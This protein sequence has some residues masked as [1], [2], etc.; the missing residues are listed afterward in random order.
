MLDGVGGAVVNGLLALGHIVVILLER[1]LALLGGVE[2]QKILEEV[3]VSAVFVAHA[4]LDVDAEVLPELLVL[5]TVVLHHL[6]KLALY[7]LFKVLTDDLELAVVLKYLTGDIQAQVGGIDNAAH[8]VE[9]IVH[10]LVAVFLNKH[11]VAVELDA[12][13]GGAAHLMVDILARDKEH[14]LVGH[15]ALGIH[16]Q[17]DCGVVLVTACLLIPLGAFLVGDIGLAALPDGHHGVNGLGLCDIDLLHD[18]VA[19]LVGLAGGLLL[20]TGNVHDYRPADIVGVFLN[21]RLELPNLQERAVDLLVGVL[22]YMHDDIRADG[23]LVAVGDGVAVSTGALPLNAGLLAVLA[24]YNGDLVG[25][26]ERRVEAHAELTDD[27]KILA[28]GLVCVH[29]ALELIR[30]G[31]CDNAE[32]GFRFGLGHADAVVGHGDEALVLIDGDADTVIGPVKADLIVGQRQV[33]QLVDSVGCIGDD[34]TQEYL[35]VGVN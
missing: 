29:L 15:I 27:G 30:A 20:L 32:V 23:V 13:L 4:A 21:Q 11:A 35:L 6:L 16:A 31:L 17:N 7:L 3:G 25:D 8:K 26:H 12:L 33:A 18:G 5:G 22:F 14:R 9:V 19:V 2:Y 24:A 34:F 1:L 28:L 10:E